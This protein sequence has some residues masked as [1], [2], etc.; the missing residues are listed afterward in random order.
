MG[1]IS[2]FHLRESPGKYLEKGAPPTQKKIIWRWFDEPVCHISL[3]LVEGVD[4]SEMLPVGV[5]RQRLAQI[6]TPGSNSTLIALCSSVYKLAACNFLLL[7][8][9]NPRRVRGANRNQQRDGALLQ[10]TF[11]TNILLRCWG[12]K[13]AT[14]WCCSNRQPS[15]HVSCEAEE[16]VNTRPPPNAKQTPM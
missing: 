11:H 10:N 13:L 9:L 4:I 2:H 7:A 3:L 14:S 16:S 6:T 1:F 15:A 12:K 8:Q 5:R